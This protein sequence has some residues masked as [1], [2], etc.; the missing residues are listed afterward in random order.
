MKGRILAVDYGLER[1][2]LAISDPLGMFA[3]PL[4]TVPTRTFFE[5]FERLNQKEKISELVI[6]IPYHTDGSENP[7][8]KDIR[9]FLAKFSSLYPDICI[10]EA[11]ERFTSVMAQQ[12][13]LSSGIRKSKRRDK[14]LKDK[15]SA[16]IL[17]NDFLER[18][19]NQKNR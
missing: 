14:G 10:H 5:F 18:R 19:K 2:G 12:V 13:I 15:I 8:I 3:Q 9:S 1:T 6:G 16:C 17:L 4:D 11:D 7:I